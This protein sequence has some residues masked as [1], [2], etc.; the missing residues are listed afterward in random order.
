MQVV[1]ER[2]Y[3]TL[4][5]PYRT[6]S[7]NISYRSHRV[8]KTKDLFKNFD[9]DIILPQNTRYYK[10]FEN[11]DFFITEYPPQIKSLYMQMNMGT[12]WYSYLNWCK[13]YGIKNGEKHFKERFSIKDINK[14]EVRIFQLLFPYTI[15]C[16]LIRPSENLL[17]A[18]VFIRKRPLENME[19]SLYTAPFYNIDNNQRICIYG[20][21]TQRNILFK[22]PYADMINSIYGQFWSSVFNHDYDYNIRSYRYQQ[23]FNNYFVWDYLSKYNPFKI[24]NSKYVKYDSLRNFMASYRERTSLTN[25]DYMSRMYKMF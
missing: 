13:R 11:Y 1:I 17:D 25:I 16:F 2:S 21:L 20:A 5:K 3:A 14:R 23:T 22:M 9:S 12:K 6:K 7:G 8:I 19:S 10:K 15:F 24:L 4:K 18:R